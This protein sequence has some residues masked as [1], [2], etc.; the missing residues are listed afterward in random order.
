MAAWEFKFLLET[1]ALV[2]L[3]LLHCFGVGFGHPICLFK[4][5]LFLRGRFYRER[6]DGEGLPSA[7]QRRCFLPR[8]LPGK[9][10]VKYSR[11]FFFYVHFPLLFSSS[12]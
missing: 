6:R 11:T 7:H 2:A 3:L 12:L 8:F 9:M 5:Y 1:L 10:E 4:I